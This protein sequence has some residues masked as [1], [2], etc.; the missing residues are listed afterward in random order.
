MGILSNGTIQSL[1]WGT[2]DREITYIIQKL[3]MQQ[4]SITQKKFFLHKCRARDIY[5]E[6][7]KHKVYYYFHKVTT[8]ILLLSLSHRYE[9][10]FLGRTKLF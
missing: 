1:L 3:H 7:Y 2:A 5:A 4:F 10:S 8:T 6:K 9:E